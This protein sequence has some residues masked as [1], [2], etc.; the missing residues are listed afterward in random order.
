MSYPLK[1]GTP[2]A[3]SMVVERSTRSPVPPIANR[4]N[5]LEN[6]KF[7][8]SKVVNN[9]SDLGTILTDVAET[10]NKYEYNN[11]RDYGWFKQ[12]YYKVKDLLTDYDYQDYRNK[13][14]YKNADAVSSQYLGDL[15]YYDNNIA[16]T[17]NQT[18]D[19]FVVRR[20]KIFNNQLMEEF[21]A[22]TIKQVIKKV[23]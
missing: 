17:I 3:R 8:Y 12:F 22:K 14:Q 19:N 11:L 4:N 1:A 6:N 20:K 21:F 5:S 15:Y 9:G 23:G 2:A 18:A 10:I 13:L 7:V 16:Y